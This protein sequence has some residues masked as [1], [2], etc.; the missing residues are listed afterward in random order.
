VESRLLGH[1]IIHLESVNSTND[2]ALQALKNG[3]ATHGT[4]ISTDFQEKGKGQRSNNWESSSGKNLLLSYVL[5]PRK[6][7]IEKSFELNFIC[8]LAV[9]DLL[10][11]LAPAYPVHV[12]WP[13]DVILNHK[14]VAGILIENALQGNYLKHSILGIG[15]NVNQKTFH[16]AH[17]TSV[18]KE[19]KDEQDLAKSVIMLNAKL[20]Y[21]YG[22]MLQGNIQEILT[23]Y[24]S[25][26]WKRGEKIS[27]I[28]NGK[29]QEIE[30][31]DVDRFGL[32]HIKTAS[33]FQ[34]AEL[35]ELKIGY[36]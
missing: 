22:K 21:W 14:K 24:N 4:L 16:I 1:H 30:I 29:Q 2:Y 11:E 33:G 34:K 15:I 20:S 5:E 32:V 31:L 28:L 6:L 25:M 36:E 9:T 35:G 8:T 12:K 13:N 17:A 26:L 7:M 18:F 3:R 23:A 19:T 27:A 10:Q